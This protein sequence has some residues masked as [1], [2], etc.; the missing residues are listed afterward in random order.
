[1]ESVFQDDIVVSEVQLTPHEQ[2]RL[3]WQQQPGFTAFLRQKNVIDQNAELL[4]FASTAGLPGWISPGL[5]ALKGLVL[6]AFIAGVINWQITRHS[7]KLEDEITALQSNAQTEVRRQEEI[8]AATQAEIS[9]IS[10]S[11]KSSFQL[12][13]SRVPLTREQALAALNSSLEESRNSEQQYQQDMAV[14]ERNLRARQSALAIA[15]SGSP[16]IFSLALLM[17]AGLFSKGAQKS[18]PRNR[19]ARNL[20]DYYLYFVTTEGLWPNLVLLAFL[21]VAFSGGDYGLTSL[22]SGVGPLFWVVFWIGF[23]ALLLRFFLMVA[24]D[25]YKAMQARPPAN[26]WGFDNRILLGIHNSFWVVFAEL[27]TVFLALCYAFY[28]IQNHAA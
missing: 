3:Q 6:I 14:R 13:I 4:P 1:M 5:F 12:H 22:F 17:A 10:N 23:Y 24:R 11:S 16:L 9:R 15:N 20:A 7:G 28:F 2:I 25:L 27:E 18:F 8:I 19:H 21:F 26:E